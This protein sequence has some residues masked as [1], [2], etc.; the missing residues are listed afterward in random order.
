MAEHIW[1]VVCYKGCIDKFTDQVSLLDV[2]EALPV[3][4]EKSSMELMERGLDVHLHL[5]SLW[6]RTKIEIP[7]LSHSRLSLQIP[8]GSITER[9]E[10][11]VD[12]RERRR[13]RTF[14]KMTSLPVRGT[15]PYAFI[16]EQRAGAEDYWKQVARLPI[17][18]WAEP[19]QSGEQLSS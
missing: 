2:V 14:F 17:E 7:E 8:D 13:I 10:L 19:A 11:E 4:F 1:S 16:V 5:V 3:P 9:D 18:I 12:L 15:G 6:I